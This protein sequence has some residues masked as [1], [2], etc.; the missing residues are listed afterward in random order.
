MSQFLTTPAFLTNNAVQEYAELVGSHHDIYDDQG[1]ANVDGL[2]SRIGGTSEYAVDSESLHVRSTGDFTIFIPHH[3]SARRDRFTKAHELGHY[4]LHYL[5]P[6][7]SGEARFGRGARDRAETEAN[8][9]ASA[10]LMPS[11]QFKRAYAEV[12]GDVW[13]LASRFDVSPRA[14]EVRAEVLGLR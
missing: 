3:T 10:L 8:V 12:G 5:Y 14:A 13:Q 7:V 6:K 9:F 1:R 4:F 2:V 11:E